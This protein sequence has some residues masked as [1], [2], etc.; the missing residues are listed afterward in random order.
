MFCFVVWG[1][2]VVTSHQTVNDHE[3]TDTEPKFLV[4]SLSSQLTESE[5]NLNSYTYIEY[6][7]SFLTVL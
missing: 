3:L 1:R 5:A 7:A 4:D 6:I 2:Q